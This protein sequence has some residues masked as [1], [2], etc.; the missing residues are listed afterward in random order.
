MICAPV[1]RARSAAVLPRLY[2]YGRG[3]RA[4]K[5]QL[6]FHRNRSCDRDRPCVYLTRDC[7]E[8]EV[9]MVLVHESLHHALHRIGEE[10][11]NDAL[12]VL[13]PNFDSTRLF[14]YP[15]NWNPSWGL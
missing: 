4:P 15:E 10:A 7:E 2:R 9:E 14:L 3:G 13:M 6:A 11:A 12:D 5:G 8:Y 1:A